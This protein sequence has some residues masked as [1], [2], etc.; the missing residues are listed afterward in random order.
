MA[1]AFYGGEGFSHNEITRIWRLNGVEGYMAPE[2][3]TIKRER[4]T[5][6]LRWLRDGRQMADDWLDLPPN[7]VK[8]RAVAAELATQLIRDGF[9]E[10]EKIVEAFARDGLELD[11]DTLIDARPVD[12]PADEIADEVTR[13]LRERPELEVALNHYEQAQ[14]A[15][16]RGDFEAANSQFRSA[17]D[18]TYDALA[19]SLGCPMDRAGGRARK[20]LQ[21]NGHIDEDEADLMKTFAA[22]AGRDGSHA[23]LS[24]A[25]ESQLRRHFAAALIAFG[26]A[27]LGQ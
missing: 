6:G 5:F 3:G 7:D 17:Y 13:L 10:R 23:G 11:G 27:K 12:G 22:F 9:M 1:S 4:V 20:W 21:D 15:F 19:Q 18:A 25:S 16:D 26:I 14:R 2:D 24:D 8:L